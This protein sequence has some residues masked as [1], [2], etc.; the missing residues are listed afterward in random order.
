MSPPPSYTSYAAFPTDVS[1]RASPSHHL[2]YQPSRVSL[3]SDAFQDTSNR[4]IL[5]HQPSCLSMVSDSSQDFFQRRPVARY[6]VPDPPQGA[7]ELP[8]ST[9]DVPKDSI[10]WEPPDCL[11]PHDPQSPK[12]SYSGVSTSQASWQ[13]PQP[14]PHQIPV[15]KSN[16]GEAAYQPPGRRASELSSISSQEA[17]RWQSPVQTPPTPFT[18]TDNESRSQLNTQRYLESISSANPL[19]RWGHSSQLSLAPS[20]ITDD[21]PGW[22]HTRQMSADT[23]TTSP[24]GSQWKTW[25][26]PVPVPP[27]PTSGDQRNQLPS[28]RQYVPPAKLTPVED[29]DDDLEAAFYKDMRMQAEERQRRR[30]ERM[31][32]KR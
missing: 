28:Q 5:S 11:R 17:S 23:S 10:D 9:Q 18:P 7:V 26:P 19:Q 8:A 6:P 3:M 25:K 22:Q 27:K 30:E 14:S 24:N 13:R 12:S 21:Q 16:M 15:A 1:D 4:S 32:S 31:G 29:D 20:L 2:S